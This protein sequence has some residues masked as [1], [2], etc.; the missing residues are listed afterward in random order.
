MRSLRACARAGARL[1]RGTAVRSA[2]A[3]LHLPQ[4][5]VSTASRGHADWRS[6]H[7]ARGRA[8]GCC[9]A[10]PRVAGGGGFACSALPWATPDARRLSASASPPPAAEPPSSQAEPA[11]AAQDA[12]PSEQSPTQYVGPLAVTLRRVKV[13]AP[14]A[15][16][17]QARGM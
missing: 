9:V 13:R 3:A 8:S 4:D 1:H 7:G 17:C 2:V 16:A 5:L 11:A 12:P 14:R 6:V 10:L 15:A